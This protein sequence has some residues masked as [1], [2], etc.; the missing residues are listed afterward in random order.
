M[1]A[2]RSYYV[3]CWPDFPAALERLR[4]KYL[5]ISYTILST[6]LAIDVSRLNGITWD[7]ILS[8]EMWGV[9]TSYSIHYTKL[10]EA[11][12]CRAARSCCPGTA[13]RTRRR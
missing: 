3:K 1:Y 6:A 11:R 5:V 13:P 7:A 12:R 9:I 10:Y 8:C 2:I 4:K